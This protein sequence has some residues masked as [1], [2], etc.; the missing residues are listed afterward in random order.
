M[1]GLDRTFLFPVR[2]LS[3]VIVYTHQRAWYKQ[4]RN[5]LENS[6]NEGP[7]MNRFSVLSALKAAVS[8]LFFL[9]G[10]V[11]AQDRPDLAGMYSDPQ[12]LVLPGAL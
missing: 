11:L 10:S 6:N 1:E 4:K 8:P 5:D 9:T 12:G 3:G 2:S 7:R